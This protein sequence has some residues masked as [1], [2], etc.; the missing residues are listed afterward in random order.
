MKI[1]LDIETVDVDVESWA[2]EYGIPV[3]DVRDDVRD[4][5]SAWCQHHIEC[6]L[7]LNPR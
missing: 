3:K 4:Y 5:F 6:T 1:K 7:E 2:L